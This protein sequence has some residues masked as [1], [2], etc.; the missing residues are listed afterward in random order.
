MPISI[1]LPLLLL[2]SLLSLLL[3]IFLLFLLLLLLRLL[4]Y[5]RSLTPLSPFFPLPPSFV[6]RCNK[7]HYIT[8]LPRSLE[9]IHVHC[10]MMYCKM[11]VHYTVSL[12][13]C[14]LLCT[15]KCRCITQ[16]TLWCTVKC[17]CITECLQDLPYTPS[18]S[19][20]ASLGVV[21]ATTHCRQV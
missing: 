20:P 8:I 9:F 13:H 11:S 2:L 16:C 4:P 18:H 21:T 7:L 5:Q 14:T 1:L 17:R 3:L 19:Y 15:V 12:I 6:L 10:I